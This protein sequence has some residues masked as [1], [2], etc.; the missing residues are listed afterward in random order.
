MLNWIEVICSV[1][2]MIGVAYVSYKSG[3]KHGDFDG[4]MRGYNDGN[5]L[6]D[7]FWTKRYFN[8]VRQNDKES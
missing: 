3:Y 8:M 1:L 6:S 2:A 4:W 7:R 5:K